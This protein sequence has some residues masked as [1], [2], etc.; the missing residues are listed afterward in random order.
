MSNF[1]DDLSMYFPKEV[2]DQACTEGFSLQRSGKGYVLNKGV[3]PSI[4]GEARLPAQ[5]FFPLLYKVWE[6]MSGKSAFEAL[7]WKYLNLRT[8]KNTIDYLFGSLASNTSRD[9]SPGVRWM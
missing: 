9:E 5:R 6:E 7:N 8:F 3:P 4:A 1:N 2:Y